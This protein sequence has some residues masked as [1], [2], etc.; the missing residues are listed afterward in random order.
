M[1][2]QLYAA[3]KEMITRYAYLDFDIDISI[4]SFLWCVSVSWSDATLH[5][6]PRQDAL[7]E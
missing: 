5:E 6:I 3:T 4:I 7:R 2:P 1:W